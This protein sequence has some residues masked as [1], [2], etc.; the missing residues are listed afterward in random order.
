MTANE[1]YDVLLGTDDEVG[2]RRKLAGRVTARVNA[3]KL[4]AA[5]R[6]KN[7]KKRQSAV[8]AVARA[9]V[10]ARNGDPAA[11]ALVSET[12]KQAVAPSAATQEDPT[13]DELESVDEQSEGCDDSEDCVSGIRFTSIAPPG[14]QGHTIF[15]WDDELLV[16]VDDEVGSIFKKIAKGIAKAGKAVAKSGL[17]KLTVGGVLT[18]ACPAIGVPA[19]AAIAMADKTIKAAK[20]GTPV[21]KQAAVRVIAA[22]QAQAAKGDA[23]AARMVG[24]IKARVKQAQEGTRI[25]L[26]VTQNG[27]IIR[28]S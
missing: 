25:C 1:A 4:V 7:P 24:I 19:A 2:A 16:G 18:L 21:Q 15:G 28:E 27:R 23:S 14:P 20:K 10:Q 13:T 26:V 3:K 11:A 6:S 5:Y 17:V 8:R 22:T 9:Q 12:K